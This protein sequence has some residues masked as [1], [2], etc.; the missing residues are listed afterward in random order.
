MN[1]KN[2]FQYKMTSFSS[3]K[4]VILTSFNK[5]TFIKIFQKMPEDL[6]PGFIKF[7]FVFRWRVRALRN[8]LNIYS[9]R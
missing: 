7:R 8:A 2:V 1:E 5:K 3:E 6:G 9:F 4:M